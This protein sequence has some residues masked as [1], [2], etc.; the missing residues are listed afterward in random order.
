MLGTKN[1][2]AFCKNRSHPNDFCPKGKFFCTLAH[3]N[4]LRESIKPSL[5]KSVQSRR[6]CVCAAQRPTS[7]VPVLI[8]SLNPCECKTSTIHVRSMN[9]MFG[10]KNSTHSIIKTVSTNA[11]ALPTDVNNNY[12]FMFVCVKL[13]P[14]FQRYKSEISKV[15]V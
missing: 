13:S 9:L 14:P 10:R 12:F 3:S 4:H 2:S 11:R 8:W 7:S 6:V 1:T 15:L 5:L